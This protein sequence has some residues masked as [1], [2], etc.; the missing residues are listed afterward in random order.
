M[1]TVIK[2]GCRKVKAHSRVVMGDTG[3]GGLKDK[4]D[5]DEVLA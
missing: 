1:K 5:Y 2:A 3:L 4:A